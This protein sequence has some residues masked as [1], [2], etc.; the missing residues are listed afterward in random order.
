MSGKTTGAR[1]TL[2]ALRADFRGSDSLYAS[3]WLLLLLFPVYRGFVE[4]P[5]TGVAALVAVAAFSAV[6]AAGFGLAERHP[7]GWSRPARCGIWVTAMLICAAA[8]WPFI[9]ALVVFFAPYI[10][11]FCAFHLRLTHAIL[12]VAGVIAAGVGITALY[13][14][15]A[16]GA[17][18][19][20]TIIVPA[21]LLL[22]A[23]VIQRQSRAEELSHE[24]ELTRQREAI[25]LDVHDVLGHTLT[26]VNLKAELARR[27]LESDPGRARVEVEEVAQL[28]RTALAEVR[29]TVTRT[30]RPDLGGELAAARRA[31]ETA[32]VETEI[33]AVDEAPPFAAA[34]VREAVTNVVRHAHASHCRITVTP[35][36]VE[37]L[38]DGR[39][40]GDVAVDG[41]VS[42]GSGA[43]DAAGAGG[44]AGVDTSASSGEGL[45]GLSRR[46][47]AVGGVFTVSAGENGGTRV[48]AQLAGAGAARAAG[49]G[50][51]ASESGARRA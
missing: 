16:V 33:T 29:Q 27:L 8:S 13:G 6:Y 20:T 47:A 17:F 38:D 25:A 30:R 31:L 7:A 37:V 44:G 34:V 2:V 45:A 42:E 10:S 41:T 12:A 5:L 28:S 39:G 11:V 9:G 14:D 36:G 22:L 51:R 15:A 40:M 46:V 19:G 4:G 35:D 1:G 26:V 21:F 3:V 43:G 48:R 18:S 49:A 32:G 24:L 50:A 23:Q